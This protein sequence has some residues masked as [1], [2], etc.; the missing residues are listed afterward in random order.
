MA[1]DEPDPDV[2]LAMNALY[3]TPRQ[4]EAWQRFEAGATAALDLVAS[5]GPG[6]HVATMAIVALLLADLE[7]NDDGRARH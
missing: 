1:N 5:F 3:D 6:R 2:R 4:R 7:G